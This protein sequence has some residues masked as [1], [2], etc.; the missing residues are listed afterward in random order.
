MITI[1]KENNRFKKEKMLNAIS[2][3]QK[4]GVFDQQLIADVYG[5]NI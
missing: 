1:L 3:I 2:A 5:S 4:V